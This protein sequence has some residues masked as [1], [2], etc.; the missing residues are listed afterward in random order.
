MRLTAPRVSPVEAVVALMD[1]GRALPINLK[2][3]LEELGERC[4]VYLPVQDAVR[5]AE[6]DDLV[7]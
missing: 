3:E 4:E 1:E 7:R 5:C 6:T 2:D